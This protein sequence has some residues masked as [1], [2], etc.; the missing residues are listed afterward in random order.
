MARI[1]DWRRL[2]WTNASGERTLN[3]TED[4]EFDED[5]L[6]VYQNGRGD[7]VSYA[8]A[9]EEADH[10]Y[11]VFLNGELVEEI[12]LGGEGDEFNF[13][14][15]EL[16]ALTFNTRAEAREAASDLQRM[17]PKLER[18]DE[19]EYDYD[20]LK[21]WAKVIGVKANQSKESLTEEVTGEEPQEVEQ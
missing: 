6:A 1:N 3:R 10:N 2:Y 4:E 7:R 5:V 18:N 12:E 20:D 21:A 16:E 13:D 8:Y 9:D 17:L 19:G 14:G 11:E 15:D